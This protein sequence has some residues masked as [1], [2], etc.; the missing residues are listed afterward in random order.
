MDAM[1]GYPIGTLTSGVVA[2]CWGCDREWLITSPERAWR[3][4][5]EHTGPGHRAQVRGYTRKARA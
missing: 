1:S 2:A 5:A 4:A 3:F